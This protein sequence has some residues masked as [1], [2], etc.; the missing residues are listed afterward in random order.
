MTKQEVVESL[1]RIA[2]NLKAIKEQKKTTVLIMKSVLRMSIDEIE[3]FLEKLKKE[4]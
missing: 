4:S 3:K 1:D 2:N